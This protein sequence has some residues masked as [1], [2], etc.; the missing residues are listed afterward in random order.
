MV[1][2]AIHDLLKDAPFSR[3]D[4]VSLPQPPDLPEPRGAGARLRDLPLRA[5]AAAGGCSS[6]PRRRSTRRA[7][8]FAPVDKK[9]RIYEPRPGRASRHCRCRAGRARWRGRSAL[10]DAPAR[11]AAR[12]I[13]VLGRRA[14]AA[15]C[16]PSPDALGAR[17]WRELHCKLIERF[18]PPS[19][20]VT[21]DYDIVHLSESAGRFLH[22]AG[23]EPTHQ[24]AARRPP[25]AAR[26]SCARRCFRAAATATCRS[27]RRRSACELDGEPA[28]VVDPRV[29]RAKDL[30]PGF[31]L[32]IFDARDAGASPTTRRSRGGAGGRAA[33][34]R[35]SSAR[36]SE[37]KWHLRDTVEQ[38]EAL[39]ARS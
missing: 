32:V 39:D 30:A 16:R 6:A 29:A 10:Q 26:S 2:F 19:V 33:R 31:L 7:T 17:S 23:G 8:L 20:I 11:P 35:T 4:L 1:L 21:R 25:G 28:Q 38:Y 13:A 22:S 36:S 18:A 9:H 27:R 34:A 3:L 5:A 37:L 12:A 14:G 24:P 15:R